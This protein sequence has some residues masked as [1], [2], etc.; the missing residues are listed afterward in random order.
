MNTPLNMTL[1]RFTDAVARFA[2]LNASNSARYREMTD[3]IARRIMALIDGDTVVLPPEAPIDLIASDNLDFSVSLSWTAPGNATGYDVQ[4][5]TAD[6]P[7]WVTVASTPTVAFMDTGLVGD[8]S[9]LYRVHATNSAGS[10]A[11]SNVAE[12]FSVDGSAP[13][14]PD[15]PTGLTVDSSTSVVELSWDAFTGATVIANL[16]RRNTSL[17]IPGPWSLIGSG[18]VT[19]YTDAA[20][21]IGSS[22]EYRIVGLNVARVASAPSASVTATV[23]DPDV[24]APDVPVQRVPEASDEAIKF[25]WRGVSASDL[26]YYEVGYGTS[27]GVYGTIV[28]VPATQTYKTISGLSNGTTYYSAVRAVD[29]SSNANTSAWSTEQS[30][31]PAAAID[32]EVPLTPPVKIATPMTRS[33][34]ITTIEVSWR[35]SPEANVTGYTVYRGESETGP[36]AAVATDI[37]DH[38]FLDTGLGEVDYFYYVTAKNVYGLVSP[39]SDVVQDRADGADA[40]SVGGGGSSSELPVIDG[41]AGLG[42][43]HAIPGDAALDRNVNYVIDV[44]DATAYSATALEQAAAIFNQRVASAPTEPGHIPLS[45]DEL[46]RVAVLLP[47]ETVNAR[48]EIN[49]NGSSNFEAA[50]PVERVRFNWGGSPSAPTKLDLLLVAPKVTADYS[51]MSLLRATAATDPDT[52]TH[53]YK[54]TCK[55]A[56]GVAYYGPSQGS[57]IEMPSPTH[58]NLEGTVAFIGWDVEIASNNGVRIGGAGNSEQT[59][60]N[61]E[62]QGSALFVL[63]RFHQDAVEPQTRG[64]NPNNENLALIG[65]GAADAASPGR[66]GKY[67]ISTA[68]AGA[69]ADG[70]YFDLPWQE[71]AAIQILDAPIAGAGAYGAVGCRFRRAGGA[72]LKVR[73]WNAY[74]AAAGSTEAVFDGCTAWDNDPTYW[75]G[76]NRNSVHASTMVDIQDFPGSVSFQN[77]HL[78]E[79]DGA[80][81]R[82]NALWPAPNPVSTRIATAAVN[83]T[84]AVLKLSST[85][86]SVAASTGYARDNVLIYNNVVYSA[87]PAGPLMTAD[88]A[89]VLTFLTNEVFSGPALPVVAYGDFNSQSGTSTTIAVGDSINAVDVTGEAPNYATSSEAVGTQ[90]CAGNL[91][92]PSVLTGA[93]YSIAGGSINSASPAFILGGYEMDPG[94]FDTAVTYTD[95]EGPLIPGVMPVD[96]SPAFPVSGFAANYYLGNSPEANKQLRIP[97]MKAGRVARVD[98]NGNDLVKWH[99]GGGGKSTIKIG[100]TEA[101]VDH[102]DAWPFDSYISLDASRDLTWSDV[103]LTANGEYDQWFFNVH[104]DGLLERPGTLI[105]DNVGIDGAAS[106]SD[107]I[108]W[109][110]REYNL[111][112]R[113]FINCDFSHITR[114]HGTYSSLNGDTLAQSCT[115]TRCASQGIQKYSRDAGY[116]QYGPDNRPQWKEQRTDILDCHFVDNG[117]QGDRP[118]YALTI[119]QGCT[120]FPADV[121]VSNCSFVEKW[122]TS[123]DNGYSTGAIVCAP[124]SQGQGSFIGPITNTVA[125]F[126]ELP[127]SGGARDLI[128]VT[129]DSKTYKW[130]SGAWRDW[131]DITGSPQKTLLVD[132][133]LFDYTVMDR[134]VLNLRAIDEITIKNSAFKYDP[135]TNTRDMVIAIDKQ[136]VDAGSPFG[137]QNQGTAC[138]TLTLK[139][140]VGEAGSGTVE[141]HLW[142]NENFGTNQIDNVR[143]TIIQITETSHA[144][145]VVTYDCQTGAILEDRA[146]DEGTDGVKPTL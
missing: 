68:G 74:G 47:T 50:V 119:Y 2:D 66:M 48:L 63:C 92:A 29:N 114:E 142:R 7:A 125:T 127:A 99:D 19:S 16:E 71:A 106:Q 1:Y 26:A 33:E 101:T 55:N 35:D 21:A 4:R 83:G 42:A 57:D 118:S 145:R 95:F 79:E 105:W 8:A 61:G 59:R 131:G 32:P 143:H 88:A 121:V 123:V 130:E 96:I 53:G 65:S 128:R 135:G 134:S 13:A 54:R 45:N 104:G 31:A 43:N 34:S 77:N 110:C 5:R 90:E 108:K 9:Y 113:S 80:D 144:D 116:S 44:S 91:A 141:V 93:P 27:T 139:N 56:N 58:T 107:K 84:N 38:V 23:G 40:G 17:T 133:C 76:L 136:N 89:E 37:E 124:S 30:K 103:N 72:A 85:G 117:Y 64:D 78:I 6:E 73:T 70:C 82:D 24:T 100:G 98:A 3:T 41:L 111:I 126:G 46:V 146:Y 112:D 129:A 94:T 115:F 60:H 122:P 14:A 69:L 12:G 52:F 138:K 81:M 28:Q 120:Q 10:S 36:F 20:V 15:V 132:N 39:D 140:V 109:G 87:R 22:Y 75:G 51:T 102:N 67:G 137:G 86:N 97:A 25:K 11:P 18:S 49:K 62:D